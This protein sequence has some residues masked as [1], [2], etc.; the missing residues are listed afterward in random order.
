MTRMLPRL[1]ILG[2]FAIVG[3]PTLA[4]ATPISIFTAPTNTYQNTANN[5]CVFY[6]PGNC[7]SD[8]AGWPAP[9]S[10]TNGAFSPLTQTYD[11]SGSFAEFQSV[12]GNSFIVGLDI[13]DTSTPQ[14]LTAFTINFLNSGNSSLASYAFAPPTSV[15]SGN[16]GV[17]Y[18]D[19]ILA[20]GC[21][22]TISGAG[23]PSCSQYTPFTT[24]AGT[25]KIVFGFSYGTT[26]NDG[27]DKVF[28]ISTTPQGTIPTPEPASLILLGSG[29]LG[30][31]TRA[32]W[33]ARK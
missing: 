33:R 22:G 14:T 10:P 25:A 30:L 2:G 17:G 28:A 15:P 21:S 6:G 20:A 27:P 12:V 24:P 4:T 16:N 3:L 19:Y 5:P 26:G 1:L 11:S 23:I 31:A 32:R 29:L 8:P 13:N 7:S 18:A 9:A